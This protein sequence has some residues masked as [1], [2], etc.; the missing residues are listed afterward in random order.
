M[1]TYRVATEASDPEL[2][3]RAEVAELLRVS[4]T[5]LSRW[6]RDGLGPPC[7]WLAPSSPRYLR[8]EV[9]SY[10]KDLD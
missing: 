4:P 2:L 10:L 1:K 5:T 7:R 9:E 3:T 6:G 8:S